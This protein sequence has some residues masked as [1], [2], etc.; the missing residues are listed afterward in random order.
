MWQDQ[1]HQ[2]ANHRVRV[3][4][5]GSINEAKQELTDFIQVYQ[6]A[7]EQPC[8]WST[9]K[10]HY[11]WLSAAHSFDSFTPRRAKFTN[12]SSGSHWRRFFE[13]LSPSWSRMPYTQGRYAVTAPCPFDR[14][15]LT[16]LDRCPLWKAVSYWIWRAR[17]DSNLRPPSS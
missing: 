14:M 6:N 3:D 8:L 7:P 15:F 13:T 2:Y 16:L 10:Y 4:G 11:R 9:W 1:R 5:R 17:K 12:P